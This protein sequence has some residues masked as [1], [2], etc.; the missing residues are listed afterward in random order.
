MKQ[1]PALPKL[2]VVL[3]QF[4]IQRG[5]NE[6]Y[7]GGMGS[8]CLTLLIVS[9]LQVSKTFY[10]HKIYNCLLQVCLYAFL[11]FSIAIHYCNIILTSVR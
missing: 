4:L 8:Y 11:F 2:V 5:L 6:V 7:N 1:Y 3:K 10:F 9:L